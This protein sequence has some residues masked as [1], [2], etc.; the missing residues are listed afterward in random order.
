MYVSFYS[1][2][3]NE[4]QSRSLKDRVAVVALEHD[5]SRVWLLHE[6][7]AVPAVTVMRPDAELIHVREGQERHLHSTE[8]NEN[9]Y[10]AD[11]ALKLASSSNIILFGHGKGNSNMKNK[12]LGY[13]HDH[14]IPLI[15]RCVDGGTVDLSAVSDK[16]LLVLAKQVWERQ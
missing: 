2:G 7:E 5:E 13:L 3:M 12:F 11:L 8:A 9:S 15:N 6:G 16:Q 1:C 14:R 10:F 4:S